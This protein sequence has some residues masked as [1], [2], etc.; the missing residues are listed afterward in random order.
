MEAE[1]LGAPYKEMY[2]EVC[3]LWDTESVEDSK[4]KEQDTDQDK[5]DTVILNWSPQQSRKEE[6]T[7]TSAPGER[8]NRNEQRKQ[9]SEGVLTSFMPPCLCNLD[10]FVKD[11]SSL[12]GKFLLKR[13]KL[14][15]QSTTSL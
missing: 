4:S 5:E 15:L 10:T 8:D 11:P 1:T 7:T 14:G 2:L 12:V 3:K 9:T 13:W 6:T